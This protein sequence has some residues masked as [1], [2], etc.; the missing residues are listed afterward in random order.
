[1]I[2]RIF[3]VSNTVGRGAV[4][5]RCATK[6]VTTDMHFV[7][8]AAANALSIIEGHK[9]IERIWHT[10]KTGRTQRL[11]KVWMALIRKAQVYILIPPYRNIGPLPP[12]ITQQ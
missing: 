9:I 10:K 2:W 11:R 6:T 4:I 7:S 8:W 1:M 12:I 3:L 5:Y